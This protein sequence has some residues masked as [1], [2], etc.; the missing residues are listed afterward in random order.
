[1]KLIVSKARSNTQRHNDMH[2]GHCVIMRVQNLNP[3]T[4]AVAEQSASIQHPDLLR[5][6]RRQR[7]YEQPHFHHIGTSKQYQD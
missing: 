1:M 5:G 7:G 6:N 3:S 4:T 2:N